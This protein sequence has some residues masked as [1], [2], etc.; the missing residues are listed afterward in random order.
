MG[1]FRT[2]AHSTQQHDLALSRHYESLLAEATSAST[3]T[4]VSSIPG[5]D[6]SLYLD[7]I[8]VQSALLRIGALLRKALR[9]SQGEDPSPPGS[10]TEEE[11]SA[12]GF[13]MPPS[14]DEADDLDTKFGGFFALLGNKA[15]GA[16]GPTDVDDALERDIE[17][18]RLRSEN[19]S[20]RR[21]LLLAEEQ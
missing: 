16:G 11:A 21:L 14:A 12:S 1:R 2:F 19:E 20:L 6:K 18:E 13:G 4:S 17:L 9:A 5:L 3:S 8:A 15:N 10:P 7:P